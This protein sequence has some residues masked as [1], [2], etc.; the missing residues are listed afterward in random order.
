V[1]IN[2]VNYCRSLNRYVYIKEKTLVIPSL[3]FTDES[4]GPAGALIQLQ[5]PWRIVSA[6]TRQFHM[7]KWTP[8]LSQWRTS[9]SYHSHAFLTSPK[10]DCLTVQETESMFHHLD[11][12]LFSSLYFYKKLTNF[13]K[14]RCERLANRGRP[15]SALSDSMRGLRISGFVQKQYRTEIAVPM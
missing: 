14:I 15:T 11:R 8:L 7:L 4:P 12:V 5:R 10:P 6:Q 3:R 1:P 2:S 9:T 13:Y